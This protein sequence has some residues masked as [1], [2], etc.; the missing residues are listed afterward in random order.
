[1]NFIRTR[2]LAVG[3][4]A[5]VVAAGLAGCGA[6]TAEPAAVA[7]SAIAKQA[8]KGVFLRLEDYDLKTSLGIPPHPRM[9]PDPPVVVTMCGSGGCKGPRTLNAGDSESLA[10]GGDVTGT[11]TYADGFKVDYRASNPVIGYP[12]IEIAS[13]AGITTCR[14]SQTTRLAEGETL[15]VGT[16]TTPICGHEFILTRSAD[17]DYKMMTIKFHG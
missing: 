15:R 10:S 14:D 8:A 5:V 13:A 2:T 7:P 3:M 6:D 16:W 4:G 17:T 12:W 9:T 1:M 11:I